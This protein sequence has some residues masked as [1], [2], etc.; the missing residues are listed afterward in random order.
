MKYL[1]QGDCLLKPIQTCDFKTRKQDNVLLAGEATGHYHRV[2]E[3]DFDLYQ[4]ANRIVLN[5]ITSCTVTHE[6]HKPITIPPG[7]Y[8]VDQVR[9]FDHLEKTM[10]R[11]ID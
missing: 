2:T 9:E 6:E 8:E 10:R 7:I 1:Q 11:V 4:E 3:G 5:A